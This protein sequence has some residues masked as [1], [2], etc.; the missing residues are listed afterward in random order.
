MDG[1][2][3]EEY[4]VIG[5]EDRKRRRSDQVVHAIMDTEDKIM[6]N[7]LYD[8]SSSN[9]EVD[10]SGRDCDAS[11]QFYLDELFKQAIQSS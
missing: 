6:A 5:L 10:F 4:I 7:K 1:T 3:E 11:N 2:E 8:G 9:K